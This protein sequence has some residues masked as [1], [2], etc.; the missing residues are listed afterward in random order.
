[1]ALSPNTIKALFGK[2]APYADDAA[3]AVANYGDD[4][5]RAVVPYADDAAKAVTNYGDDVARAIATTPPASVANPKDLASLKERLVDKRLP[6][7]HFT[8]IEPPA[9]ASE[10]A[11][12]FI[13]DFSE[14]PLWGRFPRD[15]GVLGTL[16]TDL[17]SYEAFQPAKSPAGAITIPRMDTSELVVDALTP[18]SKWGKYEFELR[19]H[20]NTALGEWYTA[21][22]NSKLERNLKPS[23]IEKIP[24]FKN[25][26]DQNTLIDFLDTEDMLKRVK[27]ATYGNIPGVS[28]ADALAYVAEMPNLSYTDPE[29]LEYLHTSLSRHYGTSKNLQ[30]LF[31]SA[32]STFLSNAEYEDAL[33]KLFDALNKLPF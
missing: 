22:R 11:G 27:D 23:P 25:A 3:V 19:P 18:N 17:G 16:V 28:D 31:G 29:T 10:I 14:D 26:K 7:D 4:V 9:P 1:M 15:T 8:H 6:Y 13:N 12:K 30:N 20:K 2:L 32:P 21:Q 24:T 5:A 33:Q